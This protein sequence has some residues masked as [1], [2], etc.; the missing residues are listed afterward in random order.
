VLAS[1]VFPA[2]ATSARRDQQQPVCCSQQQAQEPTF[3][4]ALAV[5]IP[6][7]L[8]P[9]WRLRFA[10]CILNFALTNG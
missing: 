2:P 1:D 4:A 10:F 8:I 5:D 6:E 7:H 3:A 9:A